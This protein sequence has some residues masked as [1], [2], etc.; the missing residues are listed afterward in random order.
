VTIRTLEKRLAAAAPLTAAGAV[1]FIIALQV[2]LSQALYGDGAATMMAV[3]ER[4]TVFIIDPARLH[5]QGLSQLPLLWAVEAGFRDTHV[6][7]RIYT[8][9]QLW[10]P[11]ASYVAAIFYARRNELLLGGVLLAIVVGYLVAAM[12]AHGEY[13]WAHAL[14]VLMFATLLGRETLRLRDALLI[15]ALAAVAMRVYE[16]LVFFAPLL[17][18]LALL[19]MLRDIP[20][21]S[22]AV[23]A[24]LAVFIVLIAV[25]AF[26][27]L[28]GILYPRDA[29]NLSGARN[30]AA[31]L[32]NPQLA[33]SIA[34]TAVMLAGAVASG[35][36]A[37]VAF[38]GMPAAAA[39][40]VCV[41]SL[42]ASPVQHY[43]SRAVAGISVTAVF[44]C[45][46]GVYVFAR[47]RPAMDR[48]QGPRTSF[49]AAAL[50]WLIVSV[51]VYFVIA[52]GWRNFIV[53]YGAEVNTRRGYV[54][55]EQTALQQPRYR[56]YL[57][58]WN[59]PALSYLLRDGPDRGVIGNDAGYG[60]WEP[61]D[62]RQPRPAMDGYAWK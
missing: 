28:R 59:N 10:L 50:V 17:V 1:V 54:P 56:P 2:V 48:W 20:Q 29:A 38:A 16:V 27:A 53:Q 25:A 26:I 3:I 13:V 49:V 55:L 6:L 21:P 36:F 37:R 9:G 52:L 62:P 11:A 41:P 46:S 4:R 30:L 40:L 44:A 42:W 22:L 15:V 61:F 45:L 23:R 31:V 51:L 24:A 43:L 58:S 5:V 57:W 33:L 7:A 39:L 19:R 12:L 34:V 18:A 14:G 60:G 32:D 8:L 47:V 35:R